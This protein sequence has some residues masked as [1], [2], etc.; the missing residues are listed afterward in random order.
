MGL[1]GLNAL[2]DSDPMLELI[3]RSSRPPEWPCSELP[4]NDPISDFPVIGTK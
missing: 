2:T 1:S 4:A 3:F